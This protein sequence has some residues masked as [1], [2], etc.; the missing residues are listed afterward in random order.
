M[1]GAPLRVGDQLILEEDYDETYIPS[2]QEIN[3]FARV[4]GIDPEHEPELMWLARE[5]IV[6]PLPAEWKPCQD[7]TGDIYY[8]NFANGQ[9]TWDHPCDERYRQLVIQ[10][11]EKLLDHG[12]LK[13]KDRKKKREKKKEKQE[14]EFLKC[15]ADVLSQPG[16]LPSTSFYRVS[17]PVF[18]SELATPDQEKENKLMKRNE[19]FAKGPKGKSAGMLSDSG[20]LPRHFSGLA[21]AKLHP[22]LPGKSNR[23][24]QILADVEKILGRTSSSNR[25]DSGPQPHQDV[26]ATDRQTAATVFSNSEPENLEFT[27]VSK[28][29]SETLKVSS[30]TPKGAKTGLDM[31][32]NVETS[33]FLEGEKLGRDQ[34]DGHVEG[35]GCCPSPVDSSPGGRASRPVSGVVSRDGMSLPISERELGLPPSAVSLEES[36]GPMS[37]TNALERDSELGSLAK[38]KEGKGKKKLLEQ[39]ESTELGM[40]GRESVQQAVVLKLDSQLPPF[41]IPGVET[42]TLAAAVPGEPKD[43]EIPGSNLNSGDGG[44]SSVMTSLADHLA[45]QVLGE[46]DNFSWDLQSSHE[47]DHL[48]EQLTVPKRSFPDA[49]HIQAQSS[50][51]E[52]SES[53]CCSE[54]Q[55]FCKNMM[56]RS[57]GAESGPEQPGAGQNAEPDLTRE[58]VKGANTRP[59][60]GVATFQPV[61]QQRS[62][63]D[64]TSIIPESQEGGQL[65]QNRVSTDDGSQPELLPGDQ[66]PD[67]CGKSLCDAIDEEG[68][69]A[70]NLLCPDGGEEVEGNNKGPR[71]RARLLENVHMDVSALGASFDDESAE[72]AGHVKELHSSGHLE[73]EPPVTENDGLLAQKTGQ[74]RCGKEEELNEGSAEATE[75]SL[76]TE[77]EPARQ[78]EELHLQEETQEAQQKLKTEV[79]LEMEAEKK[80]IRLAQEA[81]LQKFQE[82]LESFQRSEEAR[83]KEQMQFSLERMKKEVEAAQ[84]VE[85]MALEQESQRALS[86]LKERLRRENK[87]AM[88][89]LELQ[90]AAELQ[91]QKSTA[92]EEHQKVVSTLQMQILE[93]QR[94]GEAELEKAL[95][96]AEHHVQQKRQQVAEY[97]REL[98]DLLKEKRQEVEENHARQLEKIQE[99]HREALAKI[100]VQHEEEEQKVREAELALDLRARDVQARSAQLQAQEETLKKRKQEVLEEEEQLEQ[101]QKEAAVAAQ[102]CLEESQKQRDSLAESLVPLRQAVVALQ[103]QKVDLESRVEQLQAQSQQL[104]KQARELEETLRDKQEL[105]KERKGPSREASLLKMEALQVEDLQDSGGTPVHW[106]QAAGMSRTGEGQGQGQACYG[107]TASEA[108]KTPEEDS[109]LL[110]QVRQYISAEGASLKTAKEFLAHQTYLMQKRQAAWRDEKQPW[111]Q[112]LQEARQLDEMKS[113]VQR[114]Q[115]LLKKKEKRLR[116]LESSLAEEFS[117]EDMLKDVACKKGVTFDLSD[118][119]DTDSLMSMEE[120]T[121]KDVH[122]KPSECQWPPLDKIQCL[123]N[124]LQRISS[125]LNSILGLLTA[126]G[127][128]Q[129]LL[130]PSAKVPAAPLPQGGLPLATYISAPHGYSDAAAPVVPLAGPQWAWR[131]ALGPRPSTTSS[132]AKNSVDSLLIKKWRK[133]FPGGLPLLCGSPSATDGRLGFMASGEHFPLFQRPQTIQ[134]MLDAKKWLEE[135]KQD[136]SVHLLPSTP[137]SSASGTG[138]L[139]L[140][141]DENNQ[142]KVYR[143]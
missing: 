99:A 143:F 86:S 112:D 53:E 14:R 134:G 45:S 87:M 141:L 51:D 27:N 54:E 129:P 125:D 35:G 117:D 104:Q 18:S 140:G 49:L 10:E 2:E 91:R 119:E 116:Q 123:T 34:W 82:E 12:G 59:Q 25:V 138:L 43:Q 38:P 109:L 74:W 122:L 94:K 75:R 9:S 106:K 115:I 89:E 107:E 23:T 88:E 33:L 21:S 29:L 92:E 11:R 90:F 81:A 96:G 50:P 73:P 63:K 17:S 85:Q 105:L 22:L 1:A 60:Q 58:M 103:S 95:E 126:F 84:Q 47:S 72:Q 128:Q 30:L 70:L 139:Q 16:I 4:I 101:Q 83:L 65:G 61:E 111:N 130:F 39:Y 132:S 44:S 62:G 28:P 37:E 78:S 52:C 8:F 77:L 36:L 110:D 124:S 66:E 20:D 71:G 137:R 55:M 40:S 76:K 6:A 113:A 98:S 80:N 24:R 136:P 32:R 79:P 5:G 57:G 120:S 7:I 93:V 68:V 108:P 48:M 131:T 15:P 41:S 135:I 114:G 31:Q 97:Q 133:Y 121:P 26:T 100:Q 13:K 56:K 102:L 46:V 42:D 127:T 142:I 3:E 69:A 118:S 64:K 67:S 19:S